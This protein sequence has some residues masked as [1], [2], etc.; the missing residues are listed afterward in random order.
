M[1]GRGLKHGYTALCRSPVA[2][3]A[4]AWIETDQHCQHFDGTVAPHAGAWIETYWPGDRCTVRSPPMRGRGLKH[5]TG[6][7]CSSGC[8]APHAG[9]WIETSQTHTA[10]PS[11]RPP[12]GGVD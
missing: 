4:G 12:C 1:R 11:G 6:Y 9:A 2:P 5:Y 8:V 7:Q 10:S 3:H